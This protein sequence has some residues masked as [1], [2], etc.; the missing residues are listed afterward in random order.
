MKNNQKLKEA[1]CQTQQPP[2]MR[3]ANEFWGEFKA[4][5][6]LTPQ[7]G[8][9]ADTPVPH[10]ALRPWLGPAIS[11]AAAVLILAL[12]YL[13]GLTRPREAQFSEV[14]E[15]EVMV[16]YSGMMVMNDT[17]NRGTVIWLSGLDKD[18]EI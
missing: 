1:L 5:A 11:A 6:R 3:T 8:A 4:K 10:R 12:I 2:A 14:Q 17:R 15:V 16:E 13:P 7:A 18:S 9:A